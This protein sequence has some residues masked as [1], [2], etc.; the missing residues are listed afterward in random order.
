[1]DPGLA[2]ASTF[3]FTS[4]FIS[5]ETRSRLALMLRGR[6]PSD[7]L[8]LERSDPHPEED[9]SSQGGVM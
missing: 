6:A 7:E 4:T 3:C 2:F 8:P 5:V 1:M 9:V